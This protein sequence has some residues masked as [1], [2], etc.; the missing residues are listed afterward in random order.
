M[1]V[2]LAALVAVLVAAAPAAAQAPVTAADVQ[3]HLQRLQEIADANGGNRSAGRPGEAATVQYIRETL[4]GLGWAV[5]LQPVRF[6]YWEERTPPVV[7]DLTPYTDAVAVRGSGA[8]EVTGRVQRMKRSG[9]KRGQT[10]GFRRGRIALIPAGDCFF[11]DAVNRWRRAGARA[12]LISV[13]A[14]PTGLLPAT[15]VRSVR[16]PT[17]LVTN[18]AARRLPATPIRVKV[19]AFSQT[20][21]ATNVIAERAGTS[22]RE[23]VFAGGHLDSVPEGP[24]LNDNGSGIA[25]LLAMAAKFETVPDTIRLGF[26]SAEEWGLFGSI[27]YVASLSR[28]ERRQIGVYLN[29]DMVGSPNPV[30][31]VYEAHPSVERPLRTRLRG[32]KTIDIYGSSDHTA[33]EDARIPVS[34]IYT[35]GPERKTAAQ[36]RIWGGAAGQPRDPCYHRAC[37]T[38]AN[39]NADATARSATV[40]AETIQAFADR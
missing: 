20:R 34:G 16:I 6:P 1:R 12:V 2:L 19:D 11:R 30:F 37:D 25:A 9:C 29:A 35:G 24:G 8:G 23:V 13:P 7:H 27:R 15:L 10:R 32:A 36:A 5:T 17:L 28:A 4:A 3:P 21:T 31:E 40:L 26:W 38:L 33:F 14:G 39:V 18:A 22:P